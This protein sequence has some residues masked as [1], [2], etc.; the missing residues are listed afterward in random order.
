MHVCASLLSF[1][2]AD[3]FKFALASGLVFLCAHG[4]ITC[5]MLRAQSSVM[6]HACHASRA[7]SLRVCMS[8]ACFLAA[9]TGHACLHHCPAALSCSCHGTFVCL[10]MCVTGASFFTHG[11]HSSDYAPLCSLYPL[12]DAGARASPSPAHMLYEH[13]VQKICCAD[14]STSST[15]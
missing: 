1:V 9:C 10:H 7:C 12:S 4:R 14:C 15:M 11:L 8:R 5:A 6:V 3:A 2:F 13:P